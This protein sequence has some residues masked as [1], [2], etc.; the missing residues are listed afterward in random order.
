MRYLI[1][2]VMA[3]LSALAGFTIP[4]GMEQSMEVKKV[5][6][7]LMHISSS[8]EIDINNAEKDLGDIKK[9]LRALECT[10]QAL[11]SLQRLGVG[12]PDVQKKI[13]YWEKELNTAYYLISHI[14][15]DRRFKYYYIKLAT[16]EIQALERRISW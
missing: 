12:L 4:Y 15:K 8:L 3:S 16:A 7:Q 10:K 6:L 13:G 1:T 2:I 14:N 5:S 11:N 9:G